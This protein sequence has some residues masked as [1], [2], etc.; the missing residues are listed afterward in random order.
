MDP[1]GMTSHGFTESG[2]DVTKA[3]FSAASGPNGTVLIDLAP[4]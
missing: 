1:D 2:G 3:A 4:S